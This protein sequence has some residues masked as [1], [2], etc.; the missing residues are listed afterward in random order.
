MSDSQDS[1]VDLLGAL[2]LMLG[3][4]VDKLPV[5]K[6]VVDRVGSD[7]GTIVLTL[8][9]VQYIEDDDDGYDKPHFDL[10]LSTC[11]ISLVPFWNEDNTLEREYW[12]SEFLG[13]T[14]AEA[15]A[16]LL[17]HEWLKP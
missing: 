13:Y 3:N 8:Y 9:E 7:T 14:Y 16:S 10:V 15:E 12:E 5:K 11:Q 6:L 4:L 2:N 17:K 1:I